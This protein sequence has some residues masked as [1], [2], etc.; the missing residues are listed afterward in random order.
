M[1]S[2]IVDSPT[3]ANEEDEKKL[4]IE[5]AIDEC[6]N[7][8]KAHQSSARYSFLAALIMIFFLIFFAFYIASPYAV[9]GSERMFPDSFLFAVTGAVLT[10]ALVL[11]A[12][13]RSQLSEVARFNMMQL[14]FMRVR[15]AAKNS[16]PGFQGEV[17]TALTYRAF[18]SPEFLA[19]GKELKNEKFSNPVP[20][21]PTLEVSTAAMNKLIE[22][23][24]TLTKK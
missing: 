3:D 17:R 23:I 1:T 19:T 20:G 14:G 9:R 10:L 7:L 15:V 6:K 18:P 12:I 21:H 8:A 2:K 16:K 5:D 13:Y 11:F 24:E 22:K 4:A